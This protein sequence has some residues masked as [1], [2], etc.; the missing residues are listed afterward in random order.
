MLRSSKR[1][2]LLRL[3]RTKLG[4]GA[5]ARSVTTLEKLNFSDVL[6]SPGFAGNIA[7]VDE[8]RNLSLTYTQLNEAAAH[9]A[10][11]IE[12]ET[13]SSSYTAI[14]AFNEPGIPFV[15]AMLASWKLGKT[16]VPMSVTHSQSELDYF[17]EDSGVGLVC[18]ANNASINEHFLQTTKLPVL[19]TESLVRTAA[20]NALTD[21]EKIDFARHLRGEDS[22]AGN[23]ETG[24][25]ALV[26]YT[27]GT[28]GKPKGV[29]HT[30]GS[31]F[32]MTNSL[33]ESWRYTSHDQILHYLPLYHV[34]GLVNK[35]LCVLYSG[36][37]VEF[38]GTAAAPALWKRLALE[39]Q[40][41]QAYQRDPTTNA[42]Y[43][44]LTL[45]MAVPTIY[46]RMLEAATELKA[47]DPTSLSKA[48]SA[49]K[50]MRLMVCGSAALPDTVLV[51]WQ[52]LTGY[53]LLERYGM[54]EIGM[55]L[56][57]PYDGERRQGESV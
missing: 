37:T 12:S 11:I 50:R 21:V 18:C 53:K 35:L 40:R 23:V 47:S 4:W 33:V 30:H 17:T 20:N 26:I 55:A 15:V 46:A 3:A 14:G 10:T 39:E 5:G 28:T 25:G 16:F 49:L 29:L 27:S 42:G 51:N 56:S 54:T 57:N 19:E 24:T 44:P 45:F 8:N 6:S 38:T 48:V 22:I 34:H 43:K 36:G 7:L 1:L 2:P 32:H 52:K 41:Y 9:F 13:N 31:L